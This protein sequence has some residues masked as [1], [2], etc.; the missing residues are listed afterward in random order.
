VVGASPDVKG[1]RF[2]FFQALLK[3]GYPGKLYPINPNYS[4][5]QGHKAYSSLLDVPDSI[6]LTIITLRAPYVPP[7][8]ADCVQKRVS[9]AVIF[10]S[11]FTEGGHPELEEEV[12][13]LARKGPTRLIGPNCI[14]PY[15]PG[16]GLTFVMEERPK[17][18]GNVAFVSQSGG[19][20]ITYKTLANSRG[21]HFNKILSIGNQCDLT[22]QEVLWYYAEDPHVRVICAYVEQAKGGKE[23]SQALREVARQKPLI[24]WKGGST[25]VGA[26]AAF[27]HTGAM[28]SYSAVWEK[29]V[30]QLGVIPVDDL[31]EM[32]DATF[33]CLSIPLPKGRRVGI[34][35][36]GGGSS[37]E[38]TDACARTGLTI[39]LLA[40]ETQQ[41]L[42]RLVP[43]ANTSCKN[44]VDLGFFGFFP[45]VYAQAIRHTARDPNIDA[46]MLYQI[47]EYFAQ[48][49]A[50]FDWVEVVSSE[51]AQI[52]QE[53]SKP[54]VAVVPLLEQENLGFIGRRQA[55]VQKLRQYQIPVSPTIERAAKA[56]FRLQTYR[57][58]LDRK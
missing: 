29:S 45:K 7:I 16:S 47:T 1:D 30:S 36:A 6:D 24:I 51:L 8:V 39:P 54:F 43:E 50:G 42:A 37:V 21:I 31:E 12:K 48:F 11:G 32:S 33:A 19:H 18:V 56:L 20:S 40:D 15:C 27:S 23:F 44:P 3:S 2:P 53:I 52:R 14:G 49:N 22:V 5:I 57:R 35:V 34:V 4:E 17:G 28:A 13:A 38:M 26:R 46:L 58:F 55:F 25:E 41:E 9:F 10:S